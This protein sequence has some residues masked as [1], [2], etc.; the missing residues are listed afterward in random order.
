MFQIGQT[1]VHPGE[2]LCEVADIRTEEFVKGSPQE[3]YLLRPCGIDGGMTVYLPVNQEKIRLRTTMTAA[4][5]ASLCETAA[6]AEP[7]WVENERER[8]EKIATV[9]REGEPI[10]LMRLVQDL[11]AEQA[12]RRAIGKKLRYTDERALQDATRLL[13]EEMAA[14]LGIAPS[15]VKL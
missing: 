4:Q 11:R 14:V 5:A 1:V 9:L 15:E 2:G 3:Y 8:Q 7:V 12:K 10:A 13:R 6:A